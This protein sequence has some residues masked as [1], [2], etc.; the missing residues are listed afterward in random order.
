MASHR[1]VDLCLPC[2]AALP[3]PGPGRTGRGPLTGVHAA[4]GY[5]PPVDQLLP[6]LKFHGDL[7]AG[8]V[9]ADGMAR[10]L[11]TAPR[12]EA[13]VPVPLHASRLRSRGYDQALELARPL[14]RAL[15]LPL[16]GGVLRRVR[17]TAPQTSLDRHA[18]RRNLEGAF[19]VV[20]R[21][22]LPAHV[23][24]VDDVLTTGA[25]LRAAAQALRGAGVARVDGWACARAA[26]PRGGGGTGRG[27]V[28]TRTA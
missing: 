12:P 27:D 19:V 24:L 21:G 1:R 22:P 13:L 6:R 11:A 17:P 26:P 7:A 9:L 5:A 14:A 3:A 28:T 20:G 15:G 23:A 10:A 18:R 2:E 16:L 25:T 4:F 8:R